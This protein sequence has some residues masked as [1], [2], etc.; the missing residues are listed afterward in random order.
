MAKEAAKENPRIELIDGLRLVEYYKMARAKNVPDVP[1]PMPVE[2]R[3]RTCPR[4]SGELI[5][6]TAK[7]GE[8]SGKQFWGCSNFAKTNCT[9]TENVQ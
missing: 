6:R 4:C 3:S 8:R 1:V 2:R 7:R 9:F 5:L